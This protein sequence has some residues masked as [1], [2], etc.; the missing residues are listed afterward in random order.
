MSNLKDDLLVLKTNLE[1]IE[2]EFEQKLLEVEKKGER[3]AEL[4]KLVA[5]LIQNN[6]YIA[7]LNIGGSKYQIR[8]ASLLSVKDTIFY[9]IIVEDLEN[10]NTPTN[11]F[12]FDRNSTYFQFII[13]YL[14]THKFSLLGYKQVEL[15]DLFEEL[16][17][18]GIHPVLKIVDD[19]RKEVEFVSFECSGRYSTA[20]THKVEDLKDKSMMKGICVQSPYWIIIEFNYE[21]EFEKLEIGAWKGNSSLWA[22]T[23][24]SGAKILTSKDKI[25]WN[26]VGTIPSNFSNNVT[27]TTLKRSSAKYIKFQHTSYLGIG[28]LNIIKSTK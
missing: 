22:A 23:N 18:Y 13:D 7:N 1:E 8:I 26:E 16:E 27:M 12:F 20:G 11:D 5:D 4:D 24:G 25:S 21:H 10:N 3:F 28:Y 19:M 14:R 17:Y 15:E 2:I 9:K 6:N